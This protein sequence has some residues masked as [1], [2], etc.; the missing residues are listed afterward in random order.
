[1]ELENRLLDKNKT[2]DLSAA[3]FAPKLNVKRHTLWAWLNG[4]N[5][6]PETSFN[7]LLTE[8]GLKP[9]DLLDQASLEFYANNR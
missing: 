7:K 9:A 8:S 6:I 3:E 1:M 2:K 4:D 5:H